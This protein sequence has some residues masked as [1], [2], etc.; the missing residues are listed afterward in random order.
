ME[1]ISET[2]II[3]DGNNHVESIESV[4]NSYVSGG[5]LIVGVKT[6]E[7]NDADEHFVLNFN[8]VFNLNNVKN[9][10]IRTKTIKYDQE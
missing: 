9:Y 1:P 4:N 5:F 7:K 6:V 10:T 3:T 2:I 8:R